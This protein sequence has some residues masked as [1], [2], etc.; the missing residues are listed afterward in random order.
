MAA[1]P[2]KPPLRAFALDDA[3]NVAV[4]KLISALMPAWEKKGY[5][6]KYAG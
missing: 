3:V 6:S 4:M 1:R 2:I 5:N